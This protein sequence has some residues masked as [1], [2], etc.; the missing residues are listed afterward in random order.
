MLAPTMPAL[1]LAELTTVAVEA[2]LALPHPVALLPVGSTEPHGPHLPLATDTLLSEHTCVLAARALRAR[3]VAAVACPPLPYGVTHYADG[4]AG[5]ISLS[6]ATTEAMLR[7]LCAAH[8]AAGFE[9]VVV[10][11]HHLEPAHLDA[12]T[13]AVAGVDG[14]LFPTQLSRR[15]GRLL[16][17]EF[18]KGECHAG[19][20]E[21]SLVLA[22]RPEL[23]DE[24]VRAE[25]AEVPISLSKAM[26]EGLTTFKAMGAARGYFGNPSA[27]SA[28]EGRE[29]YAHLVEMVVTEVCES[30]S[31]GTVVG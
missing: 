27:A 9:R 2:L 5:A 23:V 15:W 1:R 16:G 8:R 14:A 12:V 7:E 6:A 3:G 4:F 21:S 17:E 26:R 10:V 25:L 19:S 31:I 29:L 28:E 24:A 20:Y 30:L 22:A 13:R 18:K 11:N